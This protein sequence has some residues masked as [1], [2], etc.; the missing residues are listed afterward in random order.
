MK[1]AVSFFAKQESL[2]RRFEQLLFFFFRQL[3]GSLR[4]KGPG[5]LRIEV[6][7]LTDL[8]VDL[9]EDI[10][11]IQKELFGVLAALADA[12]SL[13]VI[14]CA[15]F[16]DDIA[17]SGKIQDVTDVG[18][19]L[20]V[21]DIKLGLFER[22][23][24][25]VL[26]DLDPGPVSNTLTALLEG[27]DPAHVHSHGSIKLEGAAAGRHFRISEHDADLLA[28]LVDE[29]DCT[30]GFADDRRKFAEGLGH[31]AGMQADVGITHIAVDLCLGHESRHGVHY[32]NV[33]R[34]RPHHGLR[35]LQRLLAAV[36]LGNV[37]VVD[38]H[39]DILA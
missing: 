11:M 38:V 14:P 16:V 13:V 30:V 19:A 4:C 24:D 25:L 18:N 7:V 35:D 36:G 28:E 5:S 8:A 27:L 12:V 31:Q 22:R 15:A 37:E 1:T 26:Y 21:H 33:D 3:I 10:R 20:A 6:V 2:W 29:D 39:P 9:G 23:S 32:D 34:A 17:G